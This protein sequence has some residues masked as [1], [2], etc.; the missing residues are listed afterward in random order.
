LPIWITEF[1]VADANEDSNAEKLEIVY[2]T[3]YS[4]SSVEGIMTWIF[5]AGS[6]WRGPNA[7]LAR[8]DWTLTE[9]GLRYESL[10]DEWSTNASGTTGATGEFSCRGF[11]GDYEVTVA[12][13][14]A[15]PVNK[16][17]TLAPGQGGSVDYCSGTMKNN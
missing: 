17:F 16:T 12:A 13:E 1:D 5:W 14:N 9:A 7:G 11:F 6:S 2:R 10:M 15:P 4:H 3:A 8:N